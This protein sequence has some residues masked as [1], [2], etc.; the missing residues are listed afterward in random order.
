ML[1]LAWGLGLWLLTR[2][3][4]DYEMHRQN[5]NQAPVSR[6]AEGYVEVSLLSNSSGHFVTSGSLNGESV[7]FIVDTGATDVA[8]SAEL[9]AKLKLPRG[10][11]VILSTANGRVQGWRTRIT[12]LRLGDI[13]LNDV[14]ALVAPNIDGEQVLL[15]MSALRQLE[16]TQRGGTL[17]LRQHTTQE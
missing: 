14:R 2:W 4:G 9:A 1:I 6:H 10:G 3:F 11:A 13:V 16:F 8:L 7:T 5:P 17:L 12:E 15:G